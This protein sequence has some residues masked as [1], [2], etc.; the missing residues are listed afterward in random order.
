MAKAKKTAG[1][2]AA[3]R[4]SPVPRGAAT[5]ANLTKLLAA[6]SPEIRKLTRQTRG[7]VSELV[8]DAEQEIDWSSKMIGF[9]FIPGTYKGLILTVS[10]Q[11]EY[12]NII[13]AKG[14]EMLQE[15]LDTQQLLE[16]T[17]KQAR[18]IKVRGA[19]ILDRPT[20]RRLITAAAARTPRAK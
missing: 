17:G 18:H 6:Y 9:S 19:D 15:G 10:P 12:V 2:K 3:K 4:G 16:G 14:V 7:L 13:F 20:T 1:K 8:P 11:R 5:E